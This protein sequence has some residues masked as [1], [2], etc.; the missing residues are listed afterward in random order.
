MLYRAR[1]V[2]IRIV[3]VLCLL[4]GAAPLAWAQHSKDRTSV[5]AVTISRAGHFRVSGNAFQSAE[6]MLT[7]S[8]HNIVRDRFAPATRSTHDSA[9]K[10]S[11]THN[12]LV[13]AGIGAAIGGGLGAGMLIAHAGDD[14]M[15]PPAAFVIGGVLIGGLLG[16][17]FGAIAAR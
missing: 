1:Q 11:R 14:N 10:H 7:G 4:L 9:A 2:T 17:A 3:G 8:G 13:G 5:D 15:V 12:V 6:S 16:A